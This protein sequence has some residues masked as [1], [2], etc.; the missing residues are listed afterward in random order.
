MNKGSSNLP[1]L[2]SIYPSPP[3]MT[4][5]GGGV[6]DWRR[7]DSGV[8]EG[9]DAAPGTATKKVTASRWPWKLSW[10]CA[11]EHH[12]MVPVGLVDRARTRVACPA[13]YNFISVFIKSVFVIYFLYW[14]Q[15][16][17]N[18]MYTETCLLWWSDSHLHA[19]DTHKDLIKQMHPSSVVSTDGEYDWILW[20]YDPLLIERFYIACERHL[21]YLERM[22]KRLKPRRNYTIF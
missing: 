1:I 13:F 10:A 21:F 20:S 19:C 17:Y 22:I 14:T 3:D 2:K 18:N 5:I 8:R 7:G 12:G 4:S 11:I 6:G 9:D 16:M 15:H